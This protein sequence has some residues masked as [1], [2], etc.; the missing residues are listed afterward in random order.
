MRSGETVTIL[1]S[2]PLLDGFRF[3]S[4]NFLEAQRTKLG[5]KEY[6]PEPEGGHSVRLDDDNF[7][8]PGFRVSRGF[9][10]LAG[11][12]EELRGNP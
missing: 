12:N 3:T 4:L 10:E 11:E 7:T 9:S 8:G 1:C 6:E 5:L 2:T